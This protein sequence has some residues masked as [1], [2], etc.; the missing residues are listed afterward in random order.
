MKPNAMRKLQKIR[1]LKQA[2]IDA[3][4][5]GAVMYANGQG[6]KPIV[7]QHFTS[8]NQ[9]RYGWQPLSQAYF[10]WKQGLIPTKKQANFRGSKLDKNAEFM[11]KTGELTGFGKGRNLPMLVLTGK[12][13]QT[14]NS[15]SH[16][17][18]TQGGNAYIRFKNLPE[19]AVYHHEGAPPLP[20]RSPVKPNDLDKAQVIE[21]MKAYIRRSTGQ[22]P[23]KRTI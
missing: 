7:D 21:H 1:K 13:R 15:K 23:N 18:S 20:E 4:R 2:M 14:V 6:G 17:I 11:S 3:V 16:S 5:H 10:K 8:G 12:M 19:Y 22:Q 9:Q